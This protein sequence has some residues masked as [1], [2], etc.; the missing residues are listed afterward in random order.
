MHEPVANLNR[1]Q[2]R[3]TSRSRD[4]T[5]TTTNHQGTTEFDPYL[6]CAA[7][8][9]GKRASVAVVQE[10]QCGSLQQLWLIGQCRQVKMADQG[11]A[12]ASGLHSRQAIEQATIATHHNG[13][14]LIGI[15]PFELHVLPG[16]VGPII[17]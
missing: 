6:E 2:L 15:Q 1:Q 8:W 14:Q 3:N 17:H 4:A 7:L 5:A 11:S 10:E 16:N 12:K 9:G 13:K